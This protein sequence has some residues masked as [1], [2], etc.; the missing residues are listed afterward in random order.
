MDWFGGTCGL[1]DGHVFSV[2]LGFAR[3]LPGYMIDQLRLRCRRMIVS[4]W[5]LVDGLWLRDVD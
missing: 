4:W 2:D 3:S 1:S 5:R